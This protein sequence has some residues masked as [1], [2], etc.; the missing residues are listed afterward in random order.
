MKNIWETTRGGCVDPPTHPRTSMSPHTLTET[1]F[2]Q[3]DGNVTISSDVSEF[4]DPIGIQIPTQIGFRPY[5]SI[6][7]PLPP[8]RKVIYRSN[9]NIQALTLPKITNYNMRSLWGKILN[10]SEDIMDRQSDLIF[11]T[12]VWQKVENRKHQ[13]KIEE[14]LEIHGIKYISTPRPGARRGGG[15]A[16]AVR[17]EN[18]NI[19]KLN[20]SCPKSSEVVWGILR[21]KVISGKISTIISCCFYSPPRSRK[22]AALVD[23]IAQT[24]QSLMNI[25]NNPGIII[26]GDCNDMDLSSLISIDPSLRQIVLKPTRGQKILDVIVTNLGPFYQ[27]PCIIPAILPDNSGHGAPSDH[28]G[29][30]ATPISPHEV[31][32]NRTKITKLVR[33][34]PDSLITNFDTLLVNKDF[35]FLH[36]LCRSK[37]FQRSSLPYLAKLLNSAHRNKQK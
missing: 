10:L 33:P 24:V 30:C 29:V 34:I 5:K 15:A 14:M 17:L 7:E 36:N 27:E 3:F 9:R 19:S 20:I 18:F 6:L 23:H 21:P 32:I 22:N 35:Q 2:C 28:Y 4:S 37:R 8:T 13:L 11:L 16:I 25:H 1:L 12:E 26:S 31:T